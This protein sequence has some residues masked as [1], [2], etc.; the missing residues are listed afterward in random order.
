[1]EIVDFISCIK[2]T[3]ERSKTKWQEPPA[4]LPPLHQKNKTVTMEERDYIENKSWN[5]QLNSKRTNPSWS[6]RKKRDNVAELLL[7]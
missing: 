6:N 7:C 2:A 1:L 5:Y 4:A 3:P